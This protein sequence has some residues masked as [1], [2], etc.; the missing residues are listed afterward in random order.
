MRVESGCSV[1]RANHQNRS[2]E[3]GSHFC[4]SRTGWHTSGPCSSCPETGFQ[5]K[6]EMCWFLRLSSVPCTQTSRSPGRSTFP[7]FH[8]LKIRTEHRTAPPLPDHSS[9][10]SYPPALCQGMSRTPGSLEE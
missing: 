8:C 4:F 1:V 9:D 3:W 7:G 10:V 6:T 5:L 2:P